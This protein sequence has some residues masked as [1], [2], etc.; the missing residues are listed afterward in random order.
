MSKNRKK[1]KVFDSKQQLARI[2]KKRL[3]VLI[4]SLLVAVAF[5]ILKPA[6]DSWPVW[7]IDI[8]EGFI[9]IVGF[10]TILLILMSP[11]I[12]VTES[13]PRPLSGPGKNPKTGAGGWGWIGWCTLP[14][15]EQILYSNLFLHTVPHGDIF[16]YD[17]I[18]SAVGSIG[19]KWPGGRLITSWL[20]KLQRKIGQGYDR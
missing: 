11:I 6:S 20:A 1:R 10:I 8:R 9:A 2:T 12:V 5:F 18:C 19:Y 15:E 14:I 16:E 3:T 13:D 17:S 7:M 4:T